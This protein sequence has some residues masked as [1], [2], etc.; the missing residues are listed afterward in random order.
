LAIFTDD[1][2]LVAVI[3]AGPAGLYAAQY[4][5]RHGVQV[6]IFNRDIKP[7]GLAEYAIFPS[8][9]KMRQ[10][11][12]AQFDRILSM[13]KVHYQGNVAIGQTGDIKLDQLRKIGFQ[14]FVV[15]T[16]AQQNKWLGL[17][18]EDLAGVYQANDIVFHYNR[19]PERAGIHFEIGRQVA[20]IGVGNVMLD[21]LHYLKDSQETR[22]VTAY[23][24]RGPSEVRFD[25]P[26]L[27]PVVG[28]FNLKSINEA[29]EH[30][31]PIAE[32]V[33]QGVSA[34][35]L[36]LK[37]AHEK[38]ERCDSGL[39]VEIKFLFSP[40]RLIGDKNGRVKA[41]VFEH[42]HLI[43]EAGEIL[44]F[45]TGLTETF[46]A[47]TVIFSIGS[48]VDA[49]FGLPVEGGHFVTTPMPRF[50][51]D[52]ISYEVY[53]PDICATCEDIFV[54]GWARLASEGIVG[55]ARKDAERCARAVLAYL[56]TFSPHFEIELGDVL[57]QLP[58]VD[59]KIVNGDDL[60]RLKQVE[61]ELAAKMGLDSYKFDSNVAMLRAI[62]GSLASS[63]GSD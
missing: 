63:M 13:P 35:C 15:T 20:I 33:G 59:K 58:K 11:L 48:S 3:G 18:G 5:A 31:T 38:A 12:E 7:G 40:R 55:L 21:I 9:Q 53:N 17:P 1:R 56:D 51:V 37:N 29:V 36:L 30:A 23:A 49:G 6:V 19:L 26:T 57:K 28:C 45:G 8:K 54:S 16:G 27:E 41:I 44:S 52:G 4:L 46:P 25:K 61:Q 10:G 22:Q 39:S 14:A 32:R 43:K 62:E 24:R 50:P 60:R 47:D 2:F 42:N 34:F